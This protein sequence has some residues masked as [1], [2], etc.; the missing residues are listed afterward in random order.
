M[1]EPFLGEISMFAGTYAPKGWMFCNGEKLAISGHESLFS[2][3]GTTYGGDGQ[4]TFALPD[5]RSRAPV[6]AGAG[7]NLPEVTLG[8]M[9]GI[10]PNVDE[11]GSA[12]SAG[13]YTAVNFII[14]V[15]GIYPSR[16]D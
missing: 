6:H 16:G 10:V 11:P 15:D 3:L 2:L 1:S 4:K 7:H 14:A 5:L 9:G 13:P 8:D 12:Y